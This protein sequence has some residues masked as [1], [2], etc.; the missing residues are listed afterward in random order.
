M[1]R[2]APTL[3]YLLLIILTGC[4]TQSSDSVGRNPRAARINVDLGVNYLNQNELPLAQAKLARALK[5]D[6]DLAI[7]HWSYG[8]LKTRLG[9]YAVAERHFLKAISLDPKDSRAHNNYG[10]F[11]CD[12]GR[13]DDAEREFLKAVKNPLYTT[14][15][16]AYT[17]A[18]MCAFK[19]EDMNRAEN[20]FRRA[21]RAN[22]TYAPALYQMAKLTFSGGR[23][24]Q[25]RAYLQRYSEVAR[26]GP[27]SLWLSIQTEARMGNRSQVKD[28]A[29][30]LKT[31][32]PRSRET[33]LLLQS[34]QNGIF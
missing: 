11:L 22:S 9:E 12:R 25:T 21:L 29:R 10:A 30:Q 27:Q 23:Y 8:L 6:P 2:L 16:T 33:A 3:S 31:Q 14:A 5:Q 32:F 1:N 7:A 18:G 17:N 34:E 19:A 26:P 20:H 15:E 13:L 4:A 28:M 24:L